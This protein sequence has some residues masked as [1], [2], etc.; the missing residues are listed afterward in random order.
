MN[1]DVEIVRHTDACPVFADPL[2]PHGLTWRQ[3]LAC[4][5]K[6]HQPDSDEKSA[7]P[8]AP[9]SCTVRADG[10]DSHVSCEP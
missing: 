4:W 9:G 1:S 5:T 2:P 6:T 3:M 8:S 7:V 10:T